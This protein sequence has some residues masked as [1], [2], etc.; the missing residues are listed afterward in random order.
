VIVTSFQI[1]DA[2]KLVPSD[3]QRVAEAHRDPDARIWLDLQAPEAGELDDWLD[4]LQLSELPRRLC[5]EERDHPGFYPLR[6]EIVLVMPVMSE[7]EDT[8]DVEHVAFLCREDLLLTVHQRSLLSPKELAAVHM[9][10]T[11]LPERSIAGLVSAV[12]IDLSHRGLQHAISLRRSILTLAERLDRA[13]DDVEPEEILDRRSDLLSLAAVVSDQLPSLQALSTID[14]PFF[15]IKDTRDYLN[16]A[17]TNLQAADGTVTWLDQQVDALRSGFQ[18]HAQDKTNR[19]LGMLTILSAIFM[20]I[21]L[22][23]GI[24]GMNFETMPELGYPISYP[25][26][27]GLMIVIGWGMYLFFRRTGWFG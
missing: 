17:V 22:L 3:P 4:R 8:R 5:L 13:P 11:W 21:T 7:T 10:E 27:L 2:L 25:L 16:C 20:P 19:R 1:D 23:A 6:E 14:R 15:R 24:W 18:M 9:S 26:A 12:M